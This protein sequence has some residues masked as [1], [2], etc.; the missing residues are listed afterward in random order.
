MPSTAVTVAGSSQPQNGDSS[1]EV[2]MET[3]LETHTVG[4]QQKLAQEAGEISGWPD[5]LGIPSNAQISRPTPA[6]W[7]NETNWRFGSLTGDC[8]KYS[9]VAQP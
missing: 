6:D 8:Q 2:Q 7:S 4:A 3:R 1:E 5:S 9:G